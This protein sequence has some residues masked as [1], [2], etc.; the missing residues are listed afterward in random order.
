[1]KR[2]V[3]SRSVDT[4]GRAREDEAVEQMTP[5]GIVGLADAKTVL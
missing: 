4:P 3:E 2:G 5:G 1:M